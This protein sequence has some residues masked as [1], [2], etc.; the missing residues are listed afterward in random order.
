MHI[1]EATSALDS[2]SEKLVQQA[3]ENLLKT[4][5]KEMT[6]LIIAHRMSTVQNADRIFVID[7]GTVVEVGSH[8]ELLE[9]KEGTYFKMIQQSLGTL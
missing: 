8:E 7:S 4:K 6:T 2:E 5:R 3:I 9:K 1:D